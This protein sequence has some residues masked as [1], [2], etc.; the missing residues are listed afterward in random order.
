MPAYK[1]TPAPAAGPLYA[2]NWDSRGPIH[3]WR[4][5][6]T[7]DWLMFYTQAGRCLVRAEGRDYHGGAGE[8]FLYRPGTPQDYGQHEPNGRWRHVWVHWI[9]RTE[10]L[11]W[12]AW[13]ELSPGL[14]RLQGPARTSTRRLARIHAG[15]FRLALQSPPRRVPRR[16]CGRTRAAP[17]QPHQSSRGASAPRPAHPAGGRSSRAQSRRAPSAREARAA[18]WLF[19]LTI[20][21]ALSRAGGPAARPLS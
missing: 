10:V 12:L 14:H 3:G 4:P 8:V 18:L 9:P 16:Q 2:G 19:A 20:R 6:G 17:V 5:R 7:K 21:G 13:P 11:E 1:E 15:R